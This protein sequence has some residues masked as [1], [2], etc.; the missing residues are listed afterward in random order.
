MLNP[1]LILSVGVALHGPSYAFHGFS[2]TTH[3]FHDLTYNQNWDSYASVIF[4][5]WTAYGQHYRTC[6]V[7]F[8]TFIKGL[9]RIVPHVV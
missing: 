2:L 9:R 5:P 4:G 1:L 3:S 8:Q 7:Y 6:S